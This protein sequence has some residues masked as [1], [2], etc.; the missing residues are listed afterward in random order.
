MPRL[1]LALGDCCLGRVQVF[2]GVSVSVSRSLFLSSNKQDNVVL[3][4]AT[5]GPCSSLWDGLDHTS[6]SGLT[7]EQLDGRAVGHGACG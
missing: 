5:A 2:V 7:R 4:P 3:P 6:L 1:E